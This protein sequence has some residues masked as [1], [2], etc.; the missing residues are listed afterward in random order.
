M[1][2]ETIKQY[3]MRIARE[4]QAGKERA[5]RSGIACPDCGK[6][7]ANMKGRIQREYEVLKV[8]RC[9]SCGHTVEVTV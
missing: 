2:L 8:I 5:K 1:S 9:L 7:M 6:E 3:E 4:K